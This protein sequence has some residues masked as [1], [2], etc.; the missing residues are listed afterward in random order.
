MH[1]PRHLNLQNTQRCRLRGLV[2]S[3]N[4]QCSLHLRRIEVESRSFYN[5]NTSEVACER[6][7]ITSSRRH[8]SEYFDPHPSWIA[9]FTTAQKKHTHEE[10]TRRKTHEIQILVYKSNLMFAF[11]PSGAP[12]RTYVTVTPAQMGRTIFPGRARRHREDMTHI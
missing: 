6:H 4:A 3:D 8:R 11:L 10:N 12:K 7:E 9:A 2:E 5:R 1:I